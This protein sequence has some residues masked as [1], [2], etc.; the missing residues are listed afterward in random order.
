[1]ILIVGATLVKRPNLQ[2]MSFDDLIALRERISGMIASMAST[3]KR[4]LQAR[5][6]QLDGLATSRST[7]KRGTPA[8]SGRRPHALTGRKVPPKYRNPKNPSETWAGRGMMPLWM[9]EQMKA[10]RKPEAFAIGKPERLKRA[11]KRGRRK[12]AG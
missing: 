1:V 11:V 5:I 12:K 4:E 8:G 3:V 10:G 6:D 7:G 9:R 2:S